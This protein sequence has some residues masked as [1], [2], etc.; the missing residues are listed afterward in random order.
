MLT[1]NVTRVEAGIEKSN[2]EV[3][4]RY[5]YETVGCTLHAASAVVMPFF[6][7]FWQTVLTVDHKS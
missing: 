7:F 1:L 6:H 2:S 4:R 3:L 5:G